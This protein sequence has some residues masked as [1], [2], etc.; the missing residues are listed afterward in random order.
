MRALGAK[1]ADALFE[2]GTMGCL[3]CPAGCVVYLSG[4]LGSGKTTFARGLLAALGHAGRVKS[5]TYTL[6]ESYPLGVG[7]VHH[8]DLYRLAR[9]GEA[10]GLGVRDLGGPQDILLVEWPEKALGELPA[11]DLVVALAH[12]GEARTFQA[13][14]KTALGERVAKEARF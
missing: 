11:P 5:P 3:V 14:P 10:A 6:I 13:I 7:T 9:P 12:S 1:L 2:V 8:L 4:E